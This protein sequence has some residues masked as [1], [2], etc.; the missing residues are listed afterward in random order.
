M[1]VQGLLSH[2]F[3]GPVEVLRGSLHLVVG[4][5][6]LFLEIYFVFLILVEGVG[7]VHDIL[8]SIHTG[9]HGTVSLIACVREDSSA[10]LS[11]IVN[12][13][14]QFGRIVKPNVG[15]VLGSSGE[16]TSLKSGVGIAIRIVGRDSFGLSHNCWTIHVLNLNVLTV[17][18]HVLDDD[19]RA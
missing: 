9:S 19:A 5:V 12:A 17:S 6:K 16:M 11:P 3:R 2:V 10:T 14:T 8:L 4:S 15:G 1:S 18:V 13:L 7:V